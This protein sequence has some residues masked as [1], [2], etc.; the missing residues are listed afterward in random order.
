MLP[1]LIIFRQNSWDTMELL[2]KAIVN[3]AFAAILLWAV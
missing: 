2:A 1:P 3:L